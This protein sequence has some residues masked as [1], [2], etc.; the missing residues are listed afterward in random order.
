VIGNRLDNGV[1]VQLEDAWRTADI[2][3]SRDRYLAAGGLLVLALL[4]SAVGAGRSRLP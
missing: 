4:G 3:E 2:G 1:P